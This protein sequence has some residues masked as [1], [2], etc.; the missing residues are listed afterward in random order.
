MIAMSEKCFKCPLDANE[1]FEQCRY[2]NQ[3]RKDKP[4]GTEGCDKYG[5]SKDNSRRI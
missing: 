4:L 5:K 3:K 1:R 2:C